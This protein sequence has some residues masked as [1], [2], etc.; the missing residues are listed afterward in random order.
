[1]RYD[2][3]YTTH[4]SRT[5]TKKQR[6]APRRRIHRAWL[7]FAAIVF[8]MTCAFTFGAIVQ[9]FAGSDARV[10]DRSSAVFTDDRI[11]SLHGASTDTYAT[12]SRLESD[13][14]DEPERYVV[15]SGDTL[16]NIAARFAPQHS[17]KRKYI[18]ET[19]KLNGLTSSSLQIGQELNLPH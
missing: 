1:M 16:W 11:D 5:Y 3:I 9:T 4:N 19:K 15:T 18:Y 6:N 12:T 2:L 8:L 13:L 10:Y 7:R 14:V 17:D